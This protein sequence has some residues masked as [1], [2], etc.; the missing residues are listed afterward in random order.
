MDKFEKAVKD[1]MDYVTQIGGVA[2]DQQLYEEFDSDLRGS[3]GMTQDNW[4]IE[5]IQYVYDEVTRSNKE[6]SMEDAQSILDDF[7]KADNQAKTFPTYQPNACER[8]GYVGEKK[9]L[10]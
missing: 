8:V 3:L 2:T 6:L 9:K 7:L 1:S 4:L 5:L 10:K